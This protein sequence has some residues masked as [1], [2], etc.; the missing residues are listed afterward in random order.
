[1]LRNSNS[2]RDAF[3]KRSTRR[4]RG[5]IFGEEREVREMQGIGFCKF[6]Y[7]TTSGGKFRGFCSKKRERSRQVKAFVDNQLSEVD[8]IQNKS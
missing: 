7:L 8:S 1:M 5:M 3:I 2:N 4:V 6:Y